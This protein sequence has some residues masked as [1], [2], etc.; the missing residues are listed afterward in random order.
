MFYDVDVIKVS[1]ED[2]MSVAEMSA[3]AEE[4]HRQHLKVAVHAFTPASIQTALDAGADSIEHGNGVTDEQLKFMRDKGI[5]FD[6]TP[7][8]YGGRW[9]KFTEPIIVV[10][11]ASRAALAGSVE[12]S[13]Q[14]YNS[15]VQRVLKSA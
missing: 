11:P 15:L 2:D 8:F 6:L 10:S 4:A 12:R 14:R 1:I 7:T 13:R 3:I 5:F 9:S